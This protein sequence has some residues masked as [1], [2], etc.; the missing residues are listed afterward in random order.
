M[1]ARRFLIAAVLLALLCAG[2]PL[3]VERPTRIS[4]KPA[5]SIELEVSIVG[6][7]AGV[8]GVAMKAASRIDA[9]IDL[10]IEVLD[11]VAHVVGE[12]KIRGRRS[13]GR[14]DLRALDRT[15]RQIV[16][17]A[18]ISDGTARFVKVVPLNLFGGPPPAPQ[19]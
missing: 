1:I 7:P 15:P 2:G 19:R 14:V 5:A 3:V 11:G 12:R 10:E 8:F 9:D 16:V 18:T 17:R 6:D 4:C 13:D